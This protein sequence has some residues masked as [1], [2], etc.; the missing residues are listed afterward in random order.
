MGCALS[1][2]DL[3][4]RLV[5]ESPDIHSYCILED[6]ARLPP[7]WQ[8]R[9]LEVYPGLP[10]GWD[11]IYLGGI[12]PPNKPGLP[13]VLERVAPGLARIAPNQLFGQQIPTRYY[14]FCAYAYVISRAGARKILD[15][16]TEKSGYWTSADHMMCNPVDKMNNYLLDPL[17]AGASQ[18]DDPV[19]QNSDF[20]NFNRED[21][22]DSD[23]WNNN[24][25]VPA[26]EVTLQLSKKAPLSI[27]ESLQEASMRPL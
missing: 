16:I 2:L 19:Y 14:H 26:D 27:A 6:D 7:G 3:L 4:Y 24:E 8:K 18:D 10:E 21:K 5:N 13:A 1:H 23:I 12:L 22:F 20:N 17:V 25:R 11:C 15:S 9:W